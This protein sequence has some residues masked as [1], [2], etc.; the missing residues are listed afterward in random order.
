MV[1]VPIGR[2]RLL[3]IGGTGIALVAGAGSIASAM[4]P[5]DFVERL[6][7]RTLPDASFDDPSLRRFA[8]DYVRDNQQRFQGNTFALLARLDLGR[9]SLLTLPA[10]YATRRY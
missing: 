1:R 7:R 9:L 10:T 5:E 6:I 2:R 3:L 4:E 8:E